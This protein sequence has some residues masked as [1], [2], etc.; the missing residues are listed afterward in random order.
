MI[1]WYQTFVLQVALCDVANI[2]DEN[3]FKYSCYLSVQPIILPLF[4]W[5]LWHLL[6]NTPRM[7]FLFGLLFSLYPLNLLSK[8]CFF[9]FHYNISSVHSVFIF[10][11]RCCFGSFHSFQKGSFNYCVRKIS[12]KTNIL[13]PLKRTRSSVYHW[14]RNV[15]FSENFANVL[16]EWSQSLNAS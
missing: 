10:M 1:K 4:S 6:L 8:L 2:C 12:R 5:C 9:H 7:L 15:N 13:Y 3:T 11:F 14:V 16:I